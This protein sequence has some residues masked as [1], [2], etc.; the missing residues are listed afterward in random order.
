M[1]KVEL[2]DRLAIV[3]MDD[4]K[5][6]AMNPEFFADFNRALDRAAGS[7]AVVLTG[8]RSFFSGGLDL[9]RLAVLDRGRLEALYDQLHETMMRLFQFPAPVVAAVNG[10]A[11]AGG[12]ILAFQAD[13]RVMAE[14]SFKIG[15]NE[16]QLGLALPPFVVETFRG[17]LAAGALEKMSTEGPLFSPAEALA[18]GLVDEIVAPADLETRALELASRLASLPSAA[19]AES[20]RLVRGPAV[21]RVAES[22]GR[23]AKRWIDLWF[24]PDARQRI[25]DVVARL[26]AKKPAP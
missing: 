13:F 14:G 2:R 25:G 18:I 12:C 19:I 3:R 15:L 11:I 7:A 6:N 4:G 22:R 5:A 26:A 21:S 16:I 10:H 9:P 20:K 17:R 8:A 24:S 1:L 23:D